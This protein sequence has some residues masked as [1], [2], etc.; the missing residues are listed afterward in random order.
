MKITAQSGDITA[1]SA[2]GILVSLCEGAERLGPDTS[3]IVQVDKLLDGAISAMLDSGGLKGKAGEVVVLPT[4][5]RLTPRMVAVCGLGKTG[6]VS[7][8]RVREAAA[9][10]S[11]ALRKMG[12]TSLASILLG[13]GIEGLDAFSSGRAVTEGVL[14]GLY[15]FTQYKKSE[16]PEVVSLTIVTAPDVSNETVGAAITEG[17]VVAESTCLARDMV[18]EPSNY[19]TPTRM[20]EMALDLAS[21]YGFDALVIE[22][23]EMESLGM[24]GLL[25]VARGSAEP[26]KFIR[27]SY[28]GGS[29][30]SPHMALIGKGIT[31]DSGGISIKP[32]DGMWE[33]KGDM[34]GGA[35]VIAAMCAIARMKL[36]VNVTS[37][38]PATEN[39]PGG[40]AFKPG[41]II[42][43]M[44]GKSIE[45]HST[46]AEGRLALADA[47]SY[48][49]KHGMTP[50]IDIATLTGACKVA[51]GTLYS[52]VFSNDEPL[53]E[54]FMEAS[55]CAG[56]K[57]W[58]MPL[59]EEYKE[60][61]S[62]PVADVKNIGNRWGGAIT[63]ALFVGEFVGDTPW[64]HVDIAGTGDT[65]K[66][67]GVM[68]KGGTG[69]PVRTLYEMVKATAS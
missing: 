41:D 51:L 42:R 15:Q 36:Q 49:N 69:V 64:I 61:N 20:A 54:R 3:A 62:S 28:S 7:P 10:G 68:T 11:R 24:G 21:T 2:D 63:A 22:R 48:A 4:I 27:L 12:C 25:A 17:T 58:R 19:M 14:L 16:V 52:G 46:D 66:E 1:T 65:T 31:F 5:G 53:V 6:E 55:V 47:L 8:D 35:S 30:D 13:S 34:A 39:L 9:E 38:V 26:P 60:L 37:L 50:L 23:E 29:V 40:K 59:P 44:N 67:S 33:M 43:A 18:N 57:M 45:I 56:E 32:S